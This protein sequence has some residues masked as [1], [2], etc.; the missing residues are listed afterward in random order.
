MM[1]F[2]CIALLLISGSA[3]AVDPLDY[4]TPQTGTQPVALTGGDTPATYQVSC[5]SNPPTAA[6]LL[7]AAVT[8]GSTTN[9]LQAAGR[10]LR[11]RCFQNLGATAVV[12]GSSTVSA[13][14][15]WVLGSSMTSSVSPNTYCTQN[16]GAFYCAPYTGLSAITVNV[17]QETQSNP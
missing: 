5:S 6:T 11:K 13:S 8:T 1:R 15:F 9:T 4:L 3:F 2:S 10:P 16:S 14:D 17:I 12:I 7:I